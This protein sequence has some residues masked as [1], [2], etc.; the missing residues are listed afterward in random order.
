MDAG[1]IPFTSVDVKKY[2]D[3]VNK[4]NT[5]FPPNIINSI[6]GD[7]KYKEEYNNT[8]NSW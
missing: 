4:D 8:E 5:L 3:V 7:D 2:I 6:D 1:F